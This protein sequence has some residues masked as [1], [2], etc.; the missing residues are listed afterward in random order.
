MNWKDLA[1]KAGPYVA[2]LFALSTLIAGYNHYQREIGRREILIAQARK[3]GAAA[4]RRADSLEKA[5][6]V[7]TL[8]LWKIKRETDSLTVTVDRWKHDTIEVVRFVTK[9]DSTIRSCTLALATCEQR[10]GAERDGRLAAERENRILMKQM[11]G[12]LAPWRHRIEG[13]VAG[14]VLQWGISRVR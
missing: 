4:R 12:P 3:D 6:R 11:P 5:Y 14:A 8:R 2:L 1:S 10:V 7:D 9:A 13:A